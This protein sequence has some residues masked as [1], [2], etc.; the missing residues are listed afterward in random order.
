M[1]G[2]CEYLCAERGGSDI[3]VSMGHVCVCAC[4][5]RRVR[6]GQVHDKEPLSTRFSGHRTRSKNIILL[7]HDRS[8]YS[9]SSLKLQFVPLN[10]Y[11]GTKKA[12]TPYPCT[13]ILGDFFRFY[14]RIVAVPP[15]AL[16]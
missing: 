2:I 7:D 8:E 6:Y 5:Q 10:S 15:S 3:M 1:G 4:F 12:S 16:L 11:S 9:T 14:L 13:L